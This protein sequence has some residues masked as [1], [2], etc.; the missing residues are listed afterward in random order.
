MSSRPARPHVDIGGLLIVTAADEHFMPLLRGLVESLQQWGRLQRGQLA[1]LDVGLGPASRDWLREYTDTIV[2][3]EWDI[4]LDA[5][6]ATAKPH[7]RA[8][9]ARPFLP[10]Y[11]PGHET[12]LWMDAD[13]WLQ[14]W[15][16]I[17]WYVA[18]AA[19]R[20]LAIAP[21]VDRAYRH[22]RGVLNWRMERLRAYFGPAAGALLD[23]EQYLNA[24][25]FALRADAPHWARW[26]DGF[27]RGVD[28]SHGTQCCDQAA[29]NYTVWTERLPVH[30]L[31]A[32]CNWTCHLAIPAFLPATGR[33]HEP[34]VPH[35][36]IGVMHLTGGTKDYSFDFRDDQGR[37]VRSDLRFSRE[38]N[39]RAAA[40]AQPAGQRG[41]T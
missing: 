14:E 29:L 26:A 13:T 12:Y 40:G 18:A 5:K 1:C 28:A 4:P 10:K 33:F 36:S 15:Y 30:P 38:R 20:K 31:P 16:P 27:R 6:L 19:D 34:F 7:L 8:I 25:V 2:S 17:D 23:T 41:E 21:Q 24:G 39:P 11:F 9:T 35:Q 22:P 37:T 3:P 32:L